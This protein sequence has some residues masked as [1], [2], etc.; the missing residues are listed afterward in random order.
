MET[1]SEIREGSM[2][3]MFS[4]RPIVLLIRIHKY[5]L[6]VASFVILLDHV[7]EI[8]YF[9]RVPDD[10]LTVDGRFGIH[11][12]FGQPYVVRG[13]CLGHSIIVALVQ[14]SLHFE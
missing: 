4:F 6:V 8:S 11:Q 14:A 9:F 3:R 12:D 1:E 13:C 10:G 7:F 5:A 2:L